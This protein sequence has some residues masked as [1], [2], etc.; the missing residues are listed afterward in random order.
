MSC[1]SKLVTYQLQL[2][3]PHWRWR[4]YKEMYTRQ[5]LW[6]NKA[7]FW[8]AVGEAKDHRTPLAAVNVDNIFYH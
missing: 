2:S 6:E 1:T 8:Y 7:S 3:P 4:H 5:F